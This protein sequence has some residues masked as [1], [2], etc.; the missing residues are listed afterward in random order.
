M[1]CNNPNEM[2]FHPP[3]FGFVLM[4]VVKYIKCSHIPAQGSTSDDVYLALSPFP[5][6][7]LPSLIVL[8]QKWHVDLQHF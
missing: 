5:R 7:H 2:L 1:S 3:L 8:H 4:I 6:F